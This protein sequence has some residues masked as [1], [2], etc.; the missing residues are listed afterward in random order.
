MDEVRTA[1]Y[2]YVEHEGD[3]S[4]L[5]DLQTDPFQLVS[6]AQD[7]ALVTVLA[8]LRARLQRLQGSQ[9]R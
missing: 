6:R 2:V 3:L 8:N 4:E 7:A 5:Y 1:R 9:G